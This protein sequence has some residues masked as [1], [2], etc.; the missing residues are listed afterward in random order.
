MEA[1]T[2]TAAAR[3]AASAERR[4]RAAGASDRGRR[5]DGNEDRFFADP[6]GG[7]FIVADGVGGYAA[8]EVAAELACELVARRLRLKT[9]TAPERVREA[10][11][12][13]GNEIYRRSLSTPAYWGMACVLTV[14]VIEHGVVTVGHVGDTRLYVLD[15]EG[16]RKVTRDHSIVGV[17]EDAGVLS[18]AAAM[19][20]PRRNE[21]LRDVGSAPHQPDDPGFVD[22]YQFPWSPEYT[23]LLCSDG[24]TDL[25]PGESIRQALA[26]A[27]GD[28]D[29][30]A[31]ALVDL[32]NEAGGTDNVTVV[33]VAEAHA[34]PASEGYPTW[35]PLE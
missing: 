21:I 27:A 26:A 4:L 11:A 3:S 31:G 15:E 28:L 22:V 30:G 10:I 23:L 17:Q 32:A 18:E 19:Q 29:A 35:Q 6:D 13:A 8:G 14:A 2:D 9:G 24:L 5:R 25:V 34:G 1:G 33:L 12:A 16:L 7:L 20:H